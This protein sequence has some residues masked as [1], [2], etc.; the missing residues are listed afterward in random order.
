MR[1]LIPAT[2]ALTVAAP[3]AAAP[4]DVNAQAFYVDATDLMGKGM[5]AMFDKRTKPMMAQMEDAGKR[6]RAANEAAEKRGKP[7]YCVSAADKK[8]GINPQQAVAIL[9]RVPQ[10]QRQRSTLAEAWQA[11]LVREY[12]CR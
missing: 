2:L 11:A 4:A 5:R 12:P 7:I 9:G 6:A 3:L 8:K 10:A 1:Y